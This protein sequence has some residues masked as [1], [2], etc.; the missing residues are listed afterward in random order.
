M[1]RVMG[2][3]AVEDGHSVADKNKY[4]YDLFPMVLIIRQ[5]GLGRIILV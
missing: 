3:P 1:F 5:K 4:N 2:N